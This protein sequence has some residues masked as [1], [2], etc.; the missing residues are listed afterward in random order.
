[1]ACLCLDHYFPIEISN[2]IQYHLH[3]NRMKKLNTEYF[4]LIN[5]IFNNHEISMSGGK[6]YLVCINKPFFMRSR[7]I[8]RLTS[9]MYEE[10]WTEFTRFQEIP[11]RDL[12]PIMYYK[13]DDDTFYDKTPFKV[14]PKVWLS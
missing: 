3:K 13:L 10:F 1:M 8:C 12:T 11:G 2:I 5:K 9:L 4:S 14:C 7:I 6:R